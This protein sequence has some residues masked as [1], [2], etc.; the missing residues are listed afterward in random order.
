M[1]FYLYLKHFPSNGGPLR[2]GT[3]KAVHGLASGLAA[4][5]GF[6]LGRLLPRRRSIELP[7]GPADLGALYHQWSKPGGSAIN[8][9]R[10]GSRS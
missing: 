2:V 9:P 7:E 10:P 6:V 5:G 4:T 8:S 1:N 3:S